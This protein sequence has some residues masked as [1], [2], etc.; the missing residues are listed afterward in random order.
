MYKPI[1]DIHNLTNKNLIH[2]A[3]GWKP[4]QMRIKSIRTTHIWCIYL[5]NDIDCWGVLNQF[6]RFHQTPG[7]DIL[8]SARALS[9]RDDSTSISCVCACSCAAAAVPKIFYPFKT[10]SAAQR[11]LMD[12]NDFLYTSR[13]AFDSIAKTPHHARQIISGWELYVY[14]TIWWWAR[15][16]GLFLTP[17]F[18][19]CVC[20]ARSFER[21]SR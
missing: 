3:P 21:C 11:R 2:I 18:G 1:S 5:Y 15:R 4:H 19:I 13:A 6:A 17:P 16:L 12:V 10:D 7:S 14:W 20:T 8:G 9:R